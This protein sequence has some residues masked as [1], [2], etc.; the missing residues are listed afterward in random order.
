MEK[1]ISIYLIALSLFFIALV[2]SCNQPDRSGGKTGSAK[3]SSSDTAKI[4]FKE[5][6]HDFG[7]VT[8]GEKVA[9]VFSFQN[10]GTAPLVIYSATTSCGCTIS[11]F[12]KEPVLPGSGGIIEVVFDTSGRNSKQ[13]KS[14]TVK[15]NAS[16]PVILLRITCEVISSTN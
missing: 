5:Y 8:A 13:T 2:A 16:K 11:K 10:T 4:S 12:E 3:V 7:K 9:C 6:E 14:I 15:S 1:P